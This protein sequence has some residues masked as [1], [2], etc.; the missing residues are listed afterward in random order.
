MSTAFPDGCVGDGPDAVV[1][2]VPGTW[3]RKAAWTRTDSSLSSAL[4]KAGCQVVP[5]EWSHSNCY[6]ARTRAALGLA[7]QLHGQ[8]KENPGARQWVVAHSH[9]GNIA[10]HAVRYLRK[11]RADAPRVT[12]VTLATPFIHARRRT[13]SGWSFFALPVGCALVI[14]LA[15]SALAGGPHWRDWA[16]WVVLAVVALP[17]LEVLLC[18]GGAVMHWGFIG[19]GYRSRLIA[20]AQSPQVGPED[21]VVVRAAGDEASAILAAGQFLGWISALLNR[22]LTNWWLWAWFFIVFGVAVVSAM[23]GIT[24]SSSHGFRLVISVL[25]YVF[26]MGEL[27]AVGAVLVMLAAALPFGWDGPFLSIFAS[28]SAEAAPP[29]QATILQLEPFAEVQ[30]RGLAH[31]RLY[32]SEP[33]INTI[34]T[35]I[36]GSPPVSGPVEPR[37]SLEDRTRSAGQPGA[38]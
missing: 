29:G 27:V 17:A 30:N 6:R 15:S 38:T 22:L 33:V 1:T 19:P 25:V 16:Y 34:V 8:F 7:R 36:C 4:T 28:C 9:G 5:F 2:L 35:L 10:L 26:V 14:A 18:I 3:A 13:F 20:S 11:S 37:G 24:H 31:S 21:V 32:S 12:T 23:V